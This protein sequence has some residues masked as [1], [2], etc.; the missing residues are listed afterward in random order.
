MDVEKDKRDSDVWMVSWDG[1]QTLQLTSSKDSESRPRWSPDGKYLAFTTSR[2]DE[3]EKKK[4]AQ[5]WLLNRSGGEAQKLTDVK[6]GVDD[7]EWSPDSTRLVLVVSDPDPSDD[8]EKI[9]GWKKKT[10]PP[11]V[12]DRYQFKRDYAGYLEHLRD[13]LYLFD[14]A[15]KKAEPLTTRRLRRSQ[16]LVVARRHADRVCEQ[17]RPRPRSQPRQQHLRRS[18]PRPGRRRGSSRPTP[19]EDGGRPVWSPDGSTI[20]YLQSDE[21]KW[22]AYD[23]TKLA[24]DSGSRRHRRACSPSRSIARSAHRNGRPTARAC[25]S[26][27]KTIASS[28]SRAFP[29]PAGRSSR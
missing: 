16:P 6:G 11:I 29:R 12:I 9:E 23:Q 10:K 3:D 22:Y 4:G 17:A 14:I 1:T 15:T 26:P 28:T 25:T 13:H 20:A 8:P 5:V 27:W 24:A 18:R 21:A 2:G 19:G 7:Y